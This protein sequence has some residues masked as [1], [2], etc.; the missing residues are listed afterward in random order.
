VSTEGSARDFPLPIL[1]TLKSRKVHQPFSFQFSMADKAARRQ[2]F[3]SVYRRIADELI[4]ELRKENIPEEA[5]QWYRRVNNFL[6]DFLKKK[7]QNILN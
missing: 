3:E 6:P 5:I 4:D 2:R 7:I 1:S